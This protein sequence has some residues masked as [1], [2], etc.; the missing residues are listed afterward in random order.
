MDKAVADSL[1]KICFEEILTYKKPMRMQCKADALFECTGFCCDCEQKGL[2]ETEGSSKVLMS[3]G[4]TSDDF[5]AIIGQPLPTVCCSL[6]IMFLL[7]NPGADY[8]NGLP[9]TLRGVTKNPPVNHFYF[10]SGLKSWPDNPNCGNHYGDYFAYLMAKFGLSNVYITNCIKCKYDGPREEEK[11]RATAKN[12]MERFLK[13]EI[14][15]FNPKL[16]VCFGCAVSNQLVWPYLQKTGK[17]SGPK[18]HLLHPS[19]RRISWANTTARND[20]DLEQALRNM[21]AF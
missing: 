14:H 13:R 2:A 15:A 18:L 10:S 11:Y 1:R 20:Y 6:P 9:L 8:G 12:C 17:Y 19:P 21:K 4:C 16:I 5:A 7:E 3:H